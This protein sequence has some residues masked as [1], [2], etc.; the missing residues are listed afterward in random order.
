VQ[1]IVEAH[2]GTLAASRS[3]L[4]GLAWRLAF[5]LLDPQGATHG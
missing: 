2:G 3:A 4:G 1:A 5:P